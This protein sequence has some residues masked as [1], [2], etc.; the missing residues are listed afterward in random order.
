VCTYSLLDSAH[1][2]TTKADFD[3]CVAIHPTAAE[4]LVT[5]GP[6]GATP[7]DDGGAA[8]ITPVLPPRSPP[9]PKAKL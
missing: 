1:L 6:W 2:L 3:H 7:R 9:L 8:K 4:E 5:M